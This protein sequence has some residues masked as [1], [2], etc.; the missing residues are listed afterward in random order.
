[1]VI[2]ASDGRLEIQMMPCRRHGQEIVLI[3]RAELLSFTPTIREGELTRSERDVLGWLLKGKTNHEIGQ[4]LGSKSRTVDKHV[5][6]IF[7]KIGV[8]NRREA[9]RRYVTGNGGG[10]APGYSAGG[11]SA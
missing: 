11:P 2:S 3:L 7:R 8:K 6:R 1:L 10:G 4:I 9:I 5:E